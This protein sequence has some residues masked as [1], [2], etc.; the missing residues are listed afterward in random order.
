MFIFYAPKNFPYLIIRASAK[1][2]AFTD[3]PFKLI[4]NENHAAYTD[5]YF[6][7]IQRVIVSTRSARVSKTQDLELQKKA[8]ADAGC[9]KFLRVFR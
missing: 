3:H 2:A 6:L 8:L 9:E 1:I 7:I 5:P 4:I